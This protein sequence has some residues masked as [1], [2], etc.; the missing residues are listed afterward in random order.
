MAPV[1][2]DGHT[3][4]L[5][6]VELSKRP[7]PKTKAVTGSADGIFLASTPCVSRGPLPSTYDEPTV[8]W[9]MR[10]SDGLSAHAVIG[11]Q[12]RAAWVIWFLNGQPIGVRDFED[13][14]SAIQWSDRMQIQNWTVGWRDAH[15]STDKEC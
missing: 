1:L 13:W 3:F 7:C 15:L 10:R 12:G 5:P 4:V 14:G 8:M 2:I 11:F 9:R 6:H